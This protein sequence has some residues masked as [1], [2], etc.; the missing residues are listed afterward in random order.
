MIRIIEIIIKIGIKTLQNTIRPARLS[1][2]NRPGMIMNAK[3]MYKTENQR[4][5]ADLFPKKIASF[6]GIFLIKGIG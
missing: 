5:F 1:R 3:R 6:L 2:Y 4:Y